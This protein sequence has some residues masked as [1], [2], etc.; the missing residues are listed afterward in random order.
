MNWL[1]QKFETYAHRPALICSGHTYTYSEI[2][3][4]I[5]SKL[6]QFDN[7]L[8]SGQKVAIVGPYNFQAITT[9]FSLLENNQIIAFFSNIENTELET[10]L[11]IFKPDTI[12]SVQP[13]T[14]IIHPTKTSHQ[15]RLIDDLIKSKNAGL[16]LFTS[17]TT[18]YPKA[19]LHNLD[20]I[21]DQYKRSYTKDLNIIPLLGFD[22]IGGL[23]ILLSQFAIGGTLTIPERQTPECICE[24][25]ERYKVDVIS[26]SPTFLNLLLIGES[27][28]HYDLT[29]LKIIGYGSE[30]MPDWLLK[31]LNTTFTW[32]SFQQKYGL[33]EANA[34]RIKG[35]A[36]DSLYFQID[37]PSID[38]QIIDNELWIKGPAVFSGY[39]DLQHQSEHNNGW[40]NTGDIV[41]VDED[42]FMKILG[43]KSEIINIGGEKVFPSEIESVL[44][45]LPFIM[46]CRVFSEKSLITGNIVVAEIVSRSVLS[47]PEQKKQIRT[48]LGSKLNRYKIPVKI[49]FVENIEIN[50]RMKKSRKTQ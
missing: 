21:I 31:K 4:N 35:K 38:F 20:S 48:F 40:L 15:N 50:D 49:N 42:G 45:E 47:I 10:R 6:S 24:A 17:G 23:D 28:M 9:F 1:I 14:I 25:I 11:E 16:V 7:N 3:E 30:P 41:E 26:A 36:K 32:V 19:I 39:L 29:S 12:I 5:Q 37:D 8:I 27:Y 33:S 13:D 46:D 2:F 18:G 44:L 34:I 43:R 22:H